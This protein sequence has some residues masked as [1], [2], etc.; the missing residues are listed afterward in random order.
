MRQRSHLLYVVP[1]SLLTDHSTP[2]PVLFLKGCMVLRS[3]GAFDDAH[4][5]GG[6]GGG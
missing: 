3:R 1:L 5:R 6:R 2:L 4:G